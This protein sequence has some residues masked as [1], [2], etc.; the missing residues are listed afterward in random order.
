MR[1]LDPAEMRTLERALEILRFGS[2][3]VKNILTAQVTDI[4]SEMVSA[5]MSARANRRGA[6]KNIV[7]FH[8]RRRLTPKHVDVDTIISYLRGRITSKGKR[9]PIEEHLG[10]C[11]FCRL[12]M[13]AGMNILLRKI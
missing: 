7:P 6:Q 1:K 11:S 12:L 9:Q 8:T 4:Y 2:A 3:Q 13:S 5:A 10:G